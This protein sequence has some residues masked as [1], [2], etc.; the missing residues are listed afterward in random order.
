MQKTRKRQLGGAQSA[1]DGVVCLV[2]DRG[3][4]TLRSNDGSRQ[5]VGTRTD[6]RYVMGRWHGRNLF[7]PPKRATSRFRESRKPQPGG[8]QKVADDK[9]ADARPTRHR[10]P[11]ATRVRDAHLNGDVKR[12]SPDRNCDPGCLTYE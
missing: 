7:A 3:Q 12:D 1:T 6:Y 8:D 9:L 11:L 4:P 5:A 10:R 2:N